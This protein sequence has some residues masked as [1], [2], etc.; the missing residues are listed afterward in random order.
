MVNIVR[1]SMGSPIVDDQAMQ[2]FRNQWQAYQKLVDNNHLSHRE[3]RAI[4]HR[5]LV[6]T[7]GRPFRFLDL[8]CGDASMTV[9]ALEQTPVI[10]YHGI[11]LSAAALDMAKQTVA[12]LSC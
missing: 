2:A 6:E 8:A 9:A 3:V 4:L 5:Q 1:H 10:E 12:S 11:D 7:L